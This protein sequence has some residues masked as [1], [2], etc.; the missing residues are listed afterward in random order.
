[1][2]KILLIV[3]LLCFCSPAWATW[4]ARGVIGTNTACSAGSLTCSVT[5]TATTAGDTLIATAMIPSSSA[6]TIVSG[7]GAGTWGLGGSAWKSSSTGSVSTAYVLSATGGVTSVSVT[8]STGGASSTWAVEVRAYTSSAGGVAAE[9]VPAGTTSASCSNNC[10]TPTVTLA[11]T[12]DLIY[13]AI[14][15]GNTGCSVAS[16][17][18]NF[19]ALT[20]DGGA[21]RLNTNSGTGATFTQG[22]SCPTAAASVAAMVTIGFSETAAG[23]TTI[24]P[25]RVM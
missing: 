3:A 23:G 8:L 11:G 1:M 2:K 19:T 6:K 24:M 25:P 17:F 12:N 7:S 13:A 21:D 4:T 22:T 15:T 20:G 9:S 16:P 5:V 10:T 18:G 14:A